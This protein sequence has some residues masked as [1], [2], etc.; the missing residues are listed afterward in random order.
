M[1]FIFGWG[2]VTSKRY[3]CK[4]RNTCENCHNE[5]EWILEKRME[6]VTLF[7]IKIFPHKT[8]RI[9]YCPTC[10]FGHDLSK[11]EFEAKINPASF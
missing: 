9:H 11:E 6:W 3:A 5:T 8:E 4:E 1:I 2:D 7:F 10:T